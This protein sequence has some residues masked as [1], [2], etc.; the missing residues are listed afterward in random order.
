MD[1]PV[2]NSIAGQDK[3]FSTDRHK[4]PLRSMLIKTTGERLLIIDAA[5]VAIDG[6]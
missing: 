5:T 3:W 6:T 4:Q 1:A 2:Q